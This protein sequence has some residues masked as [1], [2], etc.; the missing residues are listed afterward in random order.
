MHALTKSLKEAIFECYFLFKLI[1][2]HGRR[3]VRTGSL[4]ST[5]TRYHLDAWA[6]RAV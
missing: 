1:T 5:V 3:I 6:K 2:Q 4:L